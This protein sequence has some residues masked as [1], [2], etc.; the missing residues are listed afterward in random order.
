MQELFFWVAFAL[1]AYLVMSP[2]INDGIII[3]SGLILMALG[4]L[5][6]AA[7]LREGCDIVNQYI[8]ASIGV[9]IVLLGFAIRIASAKAKRL[10]DWLNI[11]RPIQD[12][13]RRM[14]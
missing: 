5:G 10:T 13:E 2:S 14:Q 11:C 3:K 12:K 4:F 6:A 1:A 7:G 9:F 8:V